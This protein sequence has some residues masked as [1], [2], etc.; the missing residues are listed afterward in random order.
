MKKIVEFLIKHKWIVVL[1]VIGIVLISTVKIHGA[2]FSLE[3]FYAIFGEKSEIL[4]IDDILT[5][6]MRSIG[7]WIYQILG[8]MLDGISKAFMSVAKWDIF[9][10]PQLQVIQ[11]NMNLIFPAFATVTLVF[12]FLSRMVKGSFSQGLQNLLIIFLMITV[13]TGIVQLAKDTKVQMIDMST[14]IVGLDENTSTSEQIL[15]NSTV[16]IY[17]SLKKGKQ[18]TLND[19]PKFNL[20]Y[21]KH[22][23]RLI[24]KQLIEFYS[25][26]SD[27]A[28]EKSSLSDGLFGKGDVRYYRYHTD[29]MAVNITFLCSFIVYCLAIFKM[30]YLIW[31]EFQIVIFGSLTMLRGFF[32][33]DK[34]FSTLKALARNTGSIVVMTFSM[35]AYIVFANGVMLS[36]TLDTFWLVRPILCLSVGFCIVLGSGYILN[37]LGFDDGS[38][39]VIKSMFAGRSISRG[40]SSV[41]N[42]I[43]GM[44]SSPLNA[45]DK[46]SNNL[47]KGL[48]HFNKAPVDPNN[49]NSPMKPSYPNTPHGSAAEQNKREQA[50]NLEKMKSDKNS[51][52]W[53]APTDRQLNACEKWGIPKDEV[54]GLSR[55]QLSELQQSYGMNQSYWDGKDSG[56]NPN[57]YDSDYDNNYNNSDSSWRSD[58]MTDKQAYALEK[59]YGLH[60][61]YMN[62]W[63]KGNASDLLSGSINEDI[64]NSNT[65]EVLFSKNDILGQSNGNEDPFKS[66]DSRVDL[67][68]NAKGIDKSSNE[69]IRLYDEI[70][71]TMDKE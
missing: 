41:A 61:D 58:P 6:L 19:I 36:T 68:A 67:I 25:Y 55:G 56:M 64:Y 20:K 12:F 48:D 7:F 59:E 24:K 62:D 30:G 69:Y 27:G 71:N 10:I 13:F 28:I 33:E 65:G 35:L 50:M 66:L 54:N 21:Y 17:S 9:S 8:A 26:N 52:Y 40:V 18:I 38:H 44:I 5:D 60:G 29:Y 53:K 22:G 45:I 49:P 32:S 37:E 51:S 70:K 3:D 16:D 23:E 1:I 42:G 14:E 4:E 2:E 39:H 57:R 31:E 47:D 63:N 43:K 11:N 34:M 46:L 15:K